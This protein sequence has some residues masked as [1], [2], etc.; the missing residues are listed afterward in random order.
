MN[1][2]VRKMESSE[3]PSLNDFLYQAIFI[4]DGVEPPEYEII[5]RPE[6]RVYTHDFG[7]S[8][9]DLAFAAVADGNIVG[10]A[11]SRIMNDYGHLDENTPSLAVSLYP[12]YRGKGIGT[13]LMKALLEEVERRGYARVSLSVQK[14]NYA[15]RMYSKLG[16]EIVGENDE[17]YLMMLKFRKMER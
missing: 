7:S 15:A 16:F 17:E 6:L 3:Y 2:T 12:E 14:E 13:Q 9:H 4:P 11:W 5:Y 8:E 1:Y 10:A